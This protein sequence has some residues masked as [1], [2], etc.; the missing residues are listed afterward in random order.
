MASV[1]VIVGRFQAPDLHPGHHYLIAEVLKRHE[2]VC[3]LVGTRDAQPTVRDPLDFETRRL[4][5]RRHYPAAV[6]RRVDDRAANDVWSRQVDALLLQE[7]PGMPVTL[8]GSRDSFVNAYSGSF[9]CAV[10]G[11]VPHISATALRESAACAPEESSAFRAGV[12]Y[13]AAQRFPTAYPTVDVAILN[14]PRQEVLLARKEHDAP[15]WRFVGGFVDPQDETFEYAARR[16]ASEETGMIE[17][18]DVR[19]VTSARIPDFRYRGQ[20]DQIITSFFAAEYVFGRPV[21]TDDIAELAW[22]P[23]KSMTDLLLPHH[24]QLGEALMR[25]IGKP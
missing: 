22:H 5:I 6:I 12:I 1:G 20:R 16:E 25:F 11:A 19:Y 24:K 7:F 4:M 17:I 14:T 3:I 10:I 15:L 18:G 2:R 23:V 13:G 9:P 21:A 8:Y